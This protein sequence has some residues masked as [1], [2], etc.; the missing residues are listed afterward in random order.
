MSFENLKA[1]RP[2]SAF[3]EKTPVRHNWDYN[4]SR[5]IHR[6]R[7]LEDIKLLLNREYKPRGN[8]YFGEI[9]GIQVKIDFSTTSSCSLSAETEAELEIVYK[10]ALRI[11]P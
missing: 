8:S 11:L 2:T 6:I 4:Y 10:E 7:S 5:K 1:Q 9:T 3:Q